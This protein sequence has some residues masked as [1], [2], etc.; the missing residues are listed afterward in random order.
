MKNNKYPRYFLR[1]DGDYK[2]STV[3][4]YVIYQSGGVAYWYLGSD[5]TP[6]L[7]QRMVNEKILES[8]TKAGHYREIPKSEFALLSLDS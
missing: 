7:Y 2:N 6:P 4:I 5:C 3:T 8:R 1:E